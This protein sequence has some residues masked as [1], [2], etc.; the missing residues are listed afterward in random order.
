M[1]GCARADTEGSLHVCCF[2][3]DGE[4]GLGAGATAAFEDVGAEFGAK[5]G[6]HFARN[7]LCLIVAAGPFAG[8][9]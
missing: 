5:D 2:A 9:V 7:D 8:P 4:F 3:F 1:V 6:G